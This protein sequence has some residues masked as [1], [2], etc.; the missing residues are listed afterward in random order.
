MNTLSFYRIKHLFTS[1]FISHWK[2]E[3]KTLL[4]VLAIN[5][6]FVLIHTSLESNMG[7]FCIFAVIY[8]GK[9]FR[10]LGER[11]SAMNYLL[12]PANTEEKLLTNMVLVLLVYPI[13]LGIV[14]II[15]IGIGKLGLNV[16]AFHR[17]LNLNPVEYIYSFDFQNTLNLILCFSIFMFG[18]VYFRKNA[19]AKVLLALA[20]LFFVLVIIVIVG[21]STF[22]PD[23]TLIIDEGM[24]LIT[25]KIKLESSNLF[26][27]IFNSI[28]ILFF[29]VL[30]YF[31]LRKTEV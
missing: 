10:S 18:S 29:W 14:S 20:I 3:A 4:I 16:V 9:I 5:I 25:P 23:I 28:M 17:E 21:I 15:G 19:I 22:Y 12:V 6:F 24:I 31:R 27:N 7:F 8:A 26:F 13:L 30:S 2:T 11:N 1:Y